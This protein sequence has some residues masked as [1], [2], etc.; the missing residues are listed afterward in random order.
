MDRI[1]VGVD[2][3]D[4][5]K[6]ALRWAL[7][8]AKAHGAKVVA[9]HT[10]QIPIAPPSTFTP[11]P[12]LNF[13]EFATDLKESA[14]TLLAQVLDEVTGGSGVEVE[15]ITIEGPAAPS[16]IE[17]SADADLLVVGS[18]GHGGFTGLLLG[19]VSQSCVNHARC[20]VL[21]HKGQ[22]GQD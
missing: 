7:D 17:A 13:A 10:W 4:S 18:R 12:Q 14:D 11:A 15:A 9:V 22:T 21:V 20:P 2:G 6:D 8:E 3:S 19:S 5:S 16:L 1:V